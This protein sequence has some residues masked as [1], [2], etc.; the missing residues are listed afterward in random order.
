MDVQKHIEFGISSM[1]E[2]H[3]NHQPTQL[4]YFYETT[5]LQ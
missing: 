3:V 2:E 5:D 1:T 4:S